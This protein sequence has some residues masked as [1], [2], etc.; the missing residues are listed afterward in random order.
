MLVPLCFLSK[1]EIS[2]LF[3]PNFSLFKEKLFHNLLFLTVPLLFVYIYAF[4]KALESA[5]FQ[6]FLFSLA[7][8]SVNAVTEELLWRG[9][10]LKLFSDDKW[11]YILIS[12]LGFAIWHLAP[13]QIFPNKEPGGQISFVVFAFFLG[14]LFSTVVYNTKS[15]LLVSIAHML[16]N[17]AGLGARVYLN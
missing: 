2:G 3:R 14:T 4:P 1:Q 15:I 16:L 11:L 13:Q 8:G 5:N 7:L 9:L 12:S 10:Y 17:F 6:I